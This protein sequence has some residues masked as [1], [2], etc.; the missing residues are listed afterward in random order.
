MEKSGKGV[1]VELVEKNEKPRDEEELFEP[2]TVMECGHWYCVECIEH[3]ARPDQSS[4][5]VYMRL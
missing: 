3:G 5:R 1:L 2:F 4:A